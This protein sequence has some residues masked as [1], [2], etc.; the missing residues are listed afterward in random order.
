MEELLQQLPQHP[1]VTVS[2]QTGIPG[3]YTGEILLSIG[4]DGTVKVRNVYTN[5]ERTYAGRL[6]SAQV[7]ELGHEFAAHG[8]THI[9]P[10]SAPARVPDDLPVVLR[11]ERGAEQLYEARLW[12]ADRHSDAGLDGILKRAD[13]LIRQ[14][15]HGALPF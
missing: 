10:S 14:L 13:E 1:D 7:Q 9:K 3:W 6:D 2:V 15:S 5:G 11:I 8:F 4:G 12:H